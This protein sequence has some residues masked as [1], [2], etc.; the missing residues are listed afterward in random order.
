M[1]DDALPGELEDDFDESDLHFAAQDGDM[2]RVRQL[3]ADG[4]SPNAFDETSRTPLHYAA[5]NGHIDTMRVLLE[6]GGD[7]FGDSSTCDRRC[8]RWR[9]WMQGSGCIQGASYGNVFGEIRFQTATKMPHAMQNTSVDTRSQNWR[10]S[11][12]R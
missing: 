5:E 6:A 11:L 4:R 1:A 12:P 7:T 3:L 10:G 8:G 2:I 9:D